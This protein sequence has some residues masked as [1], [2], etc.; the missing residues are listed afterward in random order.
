MNITISGRHVSMLPN[1]P[2]SSPMS[3]ISLM[4]Q[5]SSPQPASPPA[6]N[7]SA[8]RYRSEGEDEDSA[9]PA[10]DHKD[11][12]KSRHPTFGKWT[13]REHTRFLE[14]MHLYGN[15]WTD[16][17]NYV[18]SRTAAQIRSHAQK[19][20]NRVR[21]LEIERMKKDSLHRHN[22]FVVTREY[23]NTNKVS[24]RPP[25][26]IVRRKPPTDGAVKKRRTKSPSDPLPEPRHESPSP[27]VPFVSNIVPCSP[28]SVM[29]PQGMMPF[30]CAYQQTYGT[31]YGFPIAGIPYPPINF[32]GN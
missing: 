22:I 6:N 2:L 1:A 9:H 8:E 28:S 3:C 14:A 30:F 17:V 25:T 21:R 26:T 4:P 29:T 20:Y 5:N 18:G 19:Y 10:E 13:A 15:S 32:C 11:S 16:V 27:S 12:V 23:R 24:V 7:P 31:Q